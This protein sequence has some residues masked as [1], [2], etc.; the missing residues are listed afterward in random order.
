MPAARAQTPT[1]PVTPT[2]PAAVAQ[3]EVGALLDA[4]PALPDAAA[5][6]V[7]GG[8]EPEFL[9]TLPQPPDQ[10]R[11]LFQPPAPPSPRPDL[12]RPY[13]QIDPILDS[14]C[15]GAKPG[16]FYDVQ[17]DVIK[18]HV[19]TQMSGPVKLRTG[20]MVNVGLGGSQLAWTVAPR[21]E[22]GYRLPS[23]FGEIAVSDRFFD[24]SGSGTFSGPGGV[25]PKSSRLFA[26]YTDVDY[27]S[28]EFTPWANWHMKWRFGIRQ[29][30]TFSSTAANVH[31]IAAVADNST[32]GA[33]VHAGLWFVRSFPQSGF[34][35]VNKFDIGDVFSRLRQ[36]YFAASGG[37]D[38]GTLKQNVFQQVPILNWQIGMGWQPP[39]HPNVRLYLGYVFENW[40]NVSANR[41]TSS[42]GGGFT[43]QGVVIQAGVNY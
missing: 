31:G 24:S 39:G 35:F 29:A 15:I 2:P 42:R 14:P 17:F 41:N 21:F 40:F 43:D 27:A 6:A 34:S 8:W 13:F 3:P 4:I 10:P 30:E 26:N 33:G 7:A 37:S 22:V 25:A 20:N 11:S 18:P 1:P 9:K 16:W 38:A 5:P 36:E 23:G 28:N 19:V 32:A 12:E